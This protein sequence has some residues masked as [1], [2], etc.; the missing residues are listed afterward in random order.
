M[1]GN[2]KLYLL[3]GDDSATIDVQKLILQM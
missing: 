1:F 2:S 3:Y